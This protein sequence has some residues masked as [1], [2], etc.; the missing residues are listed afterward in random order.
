MSCAE[1]AFILSNSFLLVAAPS[2]AFSAS[3][4]SFKPSCVSF[5]VLSFHRVAFLLTVLPDLL[6]PHS[7]VSNS[8]L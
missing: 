6:V 2:V 8:S 7:I 3:V 5:L 4:V 1:V